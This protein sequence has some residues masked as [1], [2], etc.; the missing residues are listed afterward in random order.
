MSTAGEHRPGGRAGRAPGAGEPGEPASGAITGRAAE[1]GEAFDA[2]VAQPSSPSPRQRDCADLPPQDVQAQR[3]Y[4]ESYTYDAVGNIKRLLH[5]SGMD[6]PWD[7][8]YHYA[9]TGN[10]LL[11]TS[12][13]GDLDLDD[14]ITYT[15]LY[16]HDAHGNM[17][18][19]HSIAGDLTWDPQDL[20]HRA[21]T[22]TWTLRTRMRRR[23]AAFPLEVQRRRPEEVRRLSYDLLQLDAEALEMVVAYSPWTR[24]RPDAGRVRL[25]RASGM[26]RSCRAAT[27][28]EVIDR[29]HLG[30]RAGAR[31]CRT[32]ASPLPRRR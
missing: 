15:G 31:R 10:R 6:T 32:R 12:V 23:R 8:R 22:V 18:E 3:N 7:R 16:D 28:G 1:S 9:D 14:H 4:V 5:T 27:L 19:M 25:P 30:E 20:G 21:R 2:A 17:T 26:D 11:K 29:P 24:G 13:P